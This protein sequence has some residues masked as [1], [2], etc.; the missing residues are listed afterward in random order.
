MPSS[1]P[2]RAVASARC[3]L[4]VGMT[5][6]RWTV[7]ETDEGL[8]FLPQ[9]PCGQFRRQRDVVMWERLVGTGEIFGRLMA[10]GST[11]RF[12]ISH[13][14]HVLHTTDPKSVLKPSVCRLLP[15]EV[16]TTI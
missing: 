9:W 7:L 15:P 10:A 4:T 12:V 16:Y 13:V 8:D 11:L 1:V 5:R 14:F 3:A 6:I 2:S